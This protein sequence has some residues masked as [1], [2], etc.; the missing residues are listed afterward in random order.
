MFTTTQ[1]ASTR[2]LVNASHS[3]LAYPAFLAGHRTVQEAMG[4]GHINTYLR[5]V[6]TTT[7]KSL[8][9]SALS[10]DAEETMVQLLDCLSKPTEADSLSRLCHDGASRLQ[11]FVIPTLL[12]RLEQG[13]DVSSLAFL[14]AAYG[15]YLQAGV[16]DK[17]QKYRVDEPQLTAA[18]WVLLNEGDVLSV[19]DIWPLAPANLRS[20][21][22]FVAPYKS[23]R[24]QIACY[25][26][27]FSLKQTLCTFWEEGTELHK[28]MMA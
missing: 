10:N 23:Y 21:P 17:G 20:F 5:T 13:K 28:G 8:A 3:V 9:S 11:E 19:L 1:E 27:A 25:G 26:L 15:H 2:P 22:Q 24:N 18:D 14:L 4:D 12:E 16:D 7:G 6:L